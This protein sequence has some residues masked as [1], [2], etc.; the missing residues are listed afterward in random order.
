MLKFV[1]AKNN[2]PTT[3]TSG[4]F[5]QGGVGE[6]FFGLKLQYNIFA[7][8]GHGYSKERKVLPLM[9]TWLP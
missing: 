8:P 6:W 1:A 7:G 2:P 4:H 3:E 9:V 5:I